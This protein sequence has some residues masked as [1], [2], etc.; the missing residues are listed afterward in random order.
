VVYNGP[1]LEFVIAPSLLK[2]IC[3]TYSEAVINEDR[4]KVTGDEAP[5]W[6]YVTV[7]GKAAQAAKT[8]EEAA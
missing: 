4:L 2:R 6:E 3:D 7:L 5:S 8:N 1:P